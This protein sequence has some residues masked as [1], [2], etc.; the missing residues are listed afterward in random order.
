MLSSAGSLSWEGSSDG[1]SEG[2][3]S[4]DSSED[5]SPGSPEGL[6]K[7]E[8]GI[9]GIA[10]HIPQKLFG[11]IVV[12]LAVFKIDAGEINDVADGKG[13]KRSARGIVRIGHIVGASL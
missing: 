6:V 2:S 5:S 1:S 11:G 3:A 12:Y 4:E 13:L 9:G 8:L 10:V 7:V